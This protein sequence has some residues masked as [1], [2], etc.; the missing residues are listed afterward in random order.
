MRHHRRHAV[1]HSRHHQHRANE[2]SLL[3]SRLIAFN[4]FR[5]DRDP[6]IAKNY[7]ELMKQKLNFVVVS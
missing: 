6:L 5:G 7:V 1:A 4:I 2:G 3:Y